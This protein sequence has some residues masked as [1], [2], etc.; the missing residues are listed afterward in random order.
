MVLAR[1]LDH[2]A[3]RKTF[4]TNRTSEILTAV[5]NAKWNHGRLKENLADVASRGIIQAKFL[6]EQLWWKGPT[7]LKSDC[8][9]IHEKTLTTEKEINK[10]TLSFNVQTS[11]QAS[12][13]RELISKYLILQDLIQ[14]TVYLRR[15][16][17]RLVR[18]TKGCCSY[19][20]KAPK[21]TPS[22]G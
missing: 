2:P 16:K 19:L 4:V 22:A 13:I 6:D 14:A 17:N 1:P 11:S 18:Q 3:R 15:W 21:Q 12:Y 10:T 8:W 5:P 9:S 7:W 20:K